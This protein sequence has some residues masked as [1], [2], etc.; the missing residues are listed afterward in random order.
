MYTFIVRSLRYGQLDRAT[1]ARATSR[2]KCKEPACGVHLQA[3]LICQFTTQYELIFH[4]NNHNCVRV[5]SFDIPFDDFICTFIFYFLFYSPYLTHLNDFSLKKTRLRCISLV[6]LYIQK[7][8][9]LSLRQLLCHKQMHTY[10][11]RSNL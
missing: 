7:K 10:I 2:H 5:L 8:I 3:S 11:D 4:N 6:F 9:S 1:V